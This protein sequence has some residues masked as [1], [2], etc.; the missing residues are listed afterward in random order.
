MFKSIINPVFALVIVSSLIGC[1][2]EEVIPSPY[3]LLTSKIWQIDEIKY[4][5]ANTNYVYKRG[6]TGNNIN[7]DDA[8]IRF[9]TDGTGNTRFQ[10]N[11]YQ[12]SN[13]QLS[14]ANDKMTF[15]M[16]NGLAIA[17]ED[18]TFTQ[19]TIKYTETYTLNGVKSLAYVTRTPQP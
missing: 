7:F 6:A 4:L 19:T 2:K 8:I 16:S 13:W 12:L 1:K 3:Q 15:T 18:M 17:W 9:N 5:Q 10:G 14:G 11:S